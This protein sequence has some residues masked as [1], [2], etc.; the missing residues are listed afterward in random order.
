MEDAEVQR[1]LVAI[2]QRTA[3][4]ENQA[5]N[6]TQ[7]L[8]STQVELQNTRAQISVPAAHSGLPKGVKTTAPNR[9]S[10]RPSVKYP[11]TKHF[12]DFASRYMRVG[13]VAPDSQVDYVT[14]HLLDGEAR[15]WYDLRLKTIPTETFDS[16]SAALNAHFANHNNQ[17]YSPFH[18]E[19]PIWGPAVGDQWL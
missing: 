1:M 15:T 7:V 4:A 13:G 5:Q 10:G 6:L 19:C 14:L 3:A 17:R 12:V 16:F 2:N 11:T 18:K 8:N 9:F